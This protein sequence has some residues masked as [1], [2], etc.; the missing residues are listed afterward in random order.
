MNTVWSFEAGRLAARDDGRI[1][2][3]W[4]AEATLGAA[5]VDLLNNCTSLSDLLLSPWRAP[6]ASMP[7]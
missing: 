2:A 4:T 7:A 3:A 5:L 6:G 1:V